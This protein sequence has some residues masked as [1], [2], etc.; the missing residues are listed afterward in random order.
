M[1][2]NSEVNFFDSL[3]RTP[4]DSV[5]DVLDMLSLIDIGIIQEV[6]ANGRASV[7]TSKICNGTPYVLTDVEVLGIGNSF[8]AFTVN[9]GGC[10]CLLFA[11]RTNIPDVR[12][13]DIDVTT[14]V[15]SS[16][17]VK[18]LPISNGRN[19]EVNA[20]FNAEGTLCVDAG[21]YQLTIASS[22]I[23][24]DSGYMCIKINN[25]NTVYVYR[26][27]EQS[28]IFEFTLGDKGLVSE[29]TNSKGSSK[30]TYS[31]SDGGAISFVHAQPGGGG[32][33]D[34]VL[35]QIDIEDDGSVTISTP[36]KI[37]ITISA[38]GVVNLSTTGA[39]TIESTDDEL[40]LKGKS[41]TI[42]GTEGEVTMR[43][44]S[45]ALTLEGTSVAINSTSESVNI[46]DG[47]FEVQK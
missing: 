20:Y 33:E 31:L 10:T 7:L 26:R 3:F 29:F 42:E 5:I 46:N 28:G 27:T 8:G 17:G 6:D 11:P 39:V 16:S 24:F 13:K 9:G 34:T 36:D 12:N 43:S 32:E 37:T 45:D 15:F 25:E 35:N 44:A 4:T 18:A 30:Y 38:E 40:T 41:V 1:D 19:L 21:K 22:Y 23:G 47:N 14:P 2:N